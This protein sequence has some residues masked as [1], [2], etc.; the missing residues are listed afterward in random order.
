[1][2][3]TIIKNSRFSPTHTALFGEGAAER[4]EP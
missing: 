4:E 2:A 1:M 3:I